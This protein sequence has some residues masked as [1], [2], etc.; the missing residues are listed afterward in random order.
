MATIELNPLQTG[1]MGCHIV[2]QYPKPDAT[3][4]SPHSAVVVII[5]Q[6]KIDRI[7]SSRITPIDSADSTWHYITLN[8]PNRLITWP[9]TQ[10]QGEPDHSEFDFLQSASI[11]QIAAYRTTGNFSPNATIT[12]EVEVNCY[13]VHRFSF[14]TGSE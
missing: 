2:D 5:D 1:L 11:E 9:E 13:D 10:S 8:T 6:S 12:I 3:D 4:V 7:S 14:E